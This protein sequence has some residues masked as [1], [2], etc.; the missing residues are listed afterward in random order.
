MKDGYV[1]IMCNMGYGTLYVGVTS[2]IC[3]RAYEHRQSAIEGFSKNTACIVLFITNVQWKSWK[4]LREKR[5]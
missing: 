2:D 4:L 3:R 1:Y 5:I